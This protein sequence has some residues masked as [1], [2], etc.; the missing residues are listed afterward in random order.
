MENFKKSVKNVLDNCGEISFAYKL[1]P[2]DWISETKIISFDKGFYRI[3]DTEHKD[4]EIIFK[5]LIFELVN[6]G[7]IVSKI[8]HNNPIIEEELADNEKGVKIGKIVKNYLD[9]VKPKTI[10]EVDFAEIENIILNRIRGI[11]EHTVYL[12]DDCEWTLNK[13][14]AK[15]D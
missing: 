9:T 2:T 15:N 11:S 1:E 7:F 14:E 10:F 12:D 4:F 3:D 6:L 5:H 13:K 8:S